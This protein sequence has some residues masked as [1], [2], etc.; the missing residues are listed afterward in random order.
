MASFLFKSF[1]M[2][3]QAIRVTHEGQFPPIA[4]RPACAAGRCAACAAVRHAGMRRGRWGAYRF[5]G[6]ERNDL[7][8]T[9]GRFA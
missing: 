5:D 7:R 9:A 1:N 6:G 8:E 4:I 3:E 2:A